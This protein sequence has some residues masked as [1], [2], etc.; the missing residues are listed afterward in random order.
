MEFIDDVLDELREKYLE[1]KAAMICAFSGGKDSSLVATLLFQMFESLEPYQMHKP[2]HILM[3]DTL[4]ETPIM[5]EYCQRTL[6]KMQRVADKLGYPIVTHLATPV[7]KSRFFYKI[8]GRGT[9]VPTGQSAHRWCT[10]HLKIS[11]TKM[12]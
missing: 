5:S 2:V 1:N 11:S 3:S 8:L 7:M 4:V 10:D 9:L 12:L 6:M